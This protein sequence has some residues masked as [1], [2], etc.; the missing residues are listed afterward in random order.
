VRSPDLQ[1]TY[2]LSGEVGGRA[3]S[4]AKLASSAFAVAEIAPTVCPEGRNV[5]S[6]V[7]AFDG[8]FSLALTTK[9]NYQ[10]GGFLLPYTFKFVDKPDETVSV[11]DDCQITLHGSLH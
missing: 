2:Q 4:D 1:I 6:H 7:A 9:R 11:N 8:V 5:K 10:S 3:P